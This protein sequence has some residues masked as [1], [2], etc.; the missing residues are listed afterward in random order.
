MRIFLGV[1]LIVCIV[2]GVIAGSTVLRASGV[3]ISREATGAT[4]CTQIDVF[5]GTEDIA[6][7]PDRQHVFV[8]AA[9]RRSE[10]PQPGGI[11]LIDFSAAPDRR[12]AER[13]SN[14]APADFHPHGISLWTG[15]DGAQRLFV[16]NHPRSGGHTVEIFDVGGAGMLT[17][18]ETIRHDALLSPNDLVA[19]GPRAFYASNDRR[20][21]GGLGAVLETYLALPL[22]SVSY[23]DG[24]SGS[25]VAEGL[26]FANGV[27]VSPGGRTLY[28]A[29]AMGRRVSVFDRAPQSGE[30]TRQDRLAVDTMPDNIELDAQG[31]LLIGAHPRA[32][33]FLAHVGDANA[34]S[35][36]HVIR[37]DPASGDVETLFYDDTGLINAASVGAYVGDTLVIGAVFE[38][39]VLACARGTGT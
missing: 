10:D 35:P 29:E 1:V 37:L 20:F 31:R 25:L 21:A 12:R 33:D 26:V 24:E 36:S 18:A 2:L 17:H 16:I 5:A 39:H 13:V 6:V 30:L 3:L 11:Y 15:E 27:A 19:V 9:D 32:L 34:I 4:Q 28:V 8:S 23:F 14:D 22:T 7:D 38:G